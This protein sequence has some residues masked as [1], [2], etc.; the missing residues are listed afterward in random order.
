MI[1]INP[2]GSVII[3]VITVT[4]KRLLISESHDDSNRCTP[5]RGKLNQHD[6]YA[7]HTSPRTPDVRFLPAI[8]VCGN[9][10]RV[11]DNVGQSHCSRGAPDIIHSMSADRSVGVNPSVFNRHRRELQLWR[12]Q[13]ATYPLPDL[14]NRLSPLF[15]SG[16]V[17]SPF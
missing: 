17:R 15:P 10:S 8:P 11:T 9:L 4:N 5:C 3:Y 14:P 16:P 12:C 7:S 2:L 13:L 6:T 1:T